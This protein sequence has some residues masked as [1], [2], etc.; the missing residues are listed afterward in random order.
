MFVH[1][2]ISCDGTPEPSEKQLHSY[3]GLLLAATGGGFSLADLRS[4]TL[5]EFD[6]RSWASLGGTAQMAASGG[7]S[8]GAVLAGE[9]SRRNSMACQKRRSAKPSAAG[10]MVVWTRKLSLERGPATRP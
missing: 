2:C 10:C 6:L 8:A 1:E 5:G 9:Y 3:C 4:G 7:A